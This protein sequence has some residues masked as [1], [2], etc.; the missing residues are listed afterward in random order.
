MDSLPLNLWNA[1]LGYKFYKDSDN[2]SARRLFRLS[3]IYLPILMLMILIHKKPR[4]E[5]EEVVAAQAVS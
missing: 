1:Y 4:T 3:L 5:Q 2:R